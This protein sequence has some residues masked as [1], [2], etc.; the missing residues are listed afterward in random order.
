MYHYVSFYLIA[1]VCFLSGCGYA[2][3]LSY[4]CQ[5]FTHKL[6]LEPTIRTC[7]ETEHGCCE[8][9]RTA[10]PGSGRRGCPGE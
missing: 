10:A 3:V 4:T 6:I 9:E 2:T 7:E 8:D 5:V 1:P